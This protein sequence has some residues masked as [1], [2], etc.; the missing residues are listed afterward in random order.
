MK[1]EYYANE[2][3]EEDELEIKLSYT[4]VKKLKN[5]LLSI[6]GLEF[7]SDNKGVFKDGSGKEIARINKDKTCVYFTKN[8]LKI[9]Y[10]I[11]VK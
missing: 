2:V 11:K 3:V 7:L 6:W 4:P 5:C 9:Q 8:V 1:K 10:S